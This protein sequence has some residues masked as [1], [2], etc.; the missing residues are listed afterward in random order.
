M[1]ESN[2]RDAVQPVKP[3]R[4]DGE[5]TLFWHASGRWAKKIRGKLSYFGRGTYE[6]ALDLY[7]Q[8]AADLHAGRL[9]RDDEPA[10]LTVHLL[11]GK[12]L[13]TKTMMVKSGDL[14]QRS[15]DDYAA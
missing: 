10:G 13:T 12:F 6:E 5:T 4:P 11:C 14:A 15:L 2:S 9:P 1:S 3:K 7:Q 8:Q